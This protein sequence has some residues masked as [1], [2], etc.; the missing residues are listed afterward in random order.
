RGWSSDAYWA[1]RMT[2]ELQRA[3]HD[4]RLVCKRGSDRRVI[5]RARAEGVD[6]IDTLV[7]GSGVKPWSDGGDLERLGRWIRDSDIVHVHRG[8]E[9]WL[10]AVA[11]RASGGARPLVRTRHIVQP[12]RAHALNR[13]LYRRATSL[14][15]TVTEAIRQQ[16]L[17]AELMPAG[18]VVA[19]PGGVDAMRFHPQETTAAARR[20]LGAPPNVPLIGLVSGFRLMKGH[21]V[22]IEALAARARA[23]RRF[24][25]VFIGTGAHEP[26]V[27]QAIATAGLSGLVNV[28]GFVEDL[29]GAMAAL[30]VALYPALESDGMSRVVFEYLAMGKPLVASRVGVVA[31]VLEDGK[32]ALLVPGGDAPALAR[33]VDR[34]LGDASLRSRLGDAAP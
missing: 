7:F 9:H 2:V 24:H 6:H 11:N 19:L 23:G 25:A 10:A 31:E 3:G 26:R 30:D 21:E 22:T 33:S 12:V 1:A 13:W 27:R 16:Y 15:V 8:K 5:A 32:S 20:Q 28:I 34:L 17:A 18:R 14:V 29:P 4:V